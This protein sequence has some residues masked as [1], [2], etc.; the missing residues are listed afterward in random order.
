MFTFRIS[1]AFN[2]LAFNLGVSL[3]SLGAETDRSVVGDSALGGL[4]TAS[5]FKKTW[6]LTF[7]SQAKFL[8]RTV[9]V[10]NTSRQ[11][12]STFAKMSLGTWYRAGAFLSAL[13]AH[14][15]LSTFTR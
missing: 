1:S 4:S 11:T 2:A 3:Q 14:T 5:G 8:V 10:S 6:V 12:G 7:S 15:S 9:I 13:S